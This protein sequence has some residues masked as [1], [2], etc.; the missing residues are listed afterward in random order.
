MY[1]CPPENAT[2][3]WERKQTYRKWKFETVYMIQSV[4]I[5]WNK[6]RRR[7]LYKGKK[8]VKSLNNI[9]KFS[10]PRKIEKIGGEKVN[11]KI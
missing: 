11:M 1:P 8:E 2:D 6:K 4:E 10:S 3:N 5:N 9:K 7:K